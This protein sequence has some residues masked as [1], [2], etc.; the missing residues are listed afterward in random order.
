MDPSATLAEA[1]QGRASARVIYND[2]VK[3]GGFPVVVNVAPHTDAW[4]R[5]IRSGKV[6]K[7]G[8][9]YVFLRHT[10]SLTTVKL[11]FNAIE[12]AQ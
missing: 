6:L 3:S 9:K 11:P 1:L 4:M 10:M 7:V 8:R 2:W 5:G 12:V